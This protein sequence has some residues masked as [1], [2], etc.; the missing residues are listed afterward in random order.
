MTKEIFNIYYSINLIT[1]YLISDYK[2]TIQNK[3]P[4]ILLS[5]ICTFEIVTLPFCLYNWSK[6][7]TFSKN[8]ILKKKQCG[9]Y[10]IQDKSSSSN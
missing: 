8:A 5:F 3:D 7:K 2:D 10:F 9:K 6:M 4:T 1:K